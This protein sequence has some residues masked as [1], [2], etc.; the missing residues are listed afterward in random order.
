MTNNK[1]INID[2]DF[3]SNIERLFADLDRKQKDFATRDENFS[4]RG[5]SNRDR[6][7]YERHAYT[8]FQ[9]E[10]DVKGARERIKDFDPTDKRQKDYKKKL[11]DSNLVE[12]DDVFKQTIEELSGTIKQSDVFQKIRHSEWSTLTKKEIDALIAETQQR[13]AKAAINGDGTQEL[14]KDLKYLKSLG[15]TKPKE[16]DSTAFERFNKR[17]NITSAL[18]RTA[19]SI[20]GGIGN[21]TGA[22]TRDI[23]NGIS[24]YQNA[25]G[26]GAGLF[27]GLAAGA[28]GSLVG[29]MGLLLQKGNELQHT[30]LD[31]QKSSNVGRGNFGGSIEGNLENIGIDRVE[32]NQRAGNVMRNRGF[33]GKGLEA[34]TLRQLQLEK[35]LGLTEGDINGVS[36]TSKYDKSGLSTQEVIAGITNNLDSKGIL[37]LDPQKFDVTILPKYL[38]KI[39]N[40]NQKQLDETGKVN[41]KQAVDLLSRFTNIGGADSVF[42]NQDIALKAIEGLTETFKNPKDDLQ[43]FRNTQAVIRAARSNGEDISN[44]PFEV[45]KRSENIQNNPDAL[46]ER[47]LEIFGDVTKD[48]LKDDAQLKAQ[49]LSRVKGVTGL[50]ATLSEEFAKEFLSDSDALKQKGVIGKFGKGFDAAGRARSNT[51]K[52]EGTEADVTNK[53]ARIGD[54]IGQGVADGIT[55]LVEFG[56][57]GAEY[58]KKISNTLDKIADFF[59]SGHTVVKANAIPL[60]KYG[61]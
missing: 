50:S 33:G 5:A 23:I 45:L 1:K 24:T 28:G 8:Q 30:Y 27:G 57:K 49:I 39:A 15:N 16:D 19:N 58:T 25:R 9:K 17:Y 46:R 52:F 56:A 7:S 12:Q 32:F 55:Q 34:E 47:M 36:R 54:T 53:V 6:L 21:T 11:A 13:K 2:V 14:D 31:L 37:S 4:L 60:N 42:K 48:Q 10:Y 59:G 51:G 22:V 41:S 35:S 38:E 20:G 61:K 26:A 43:Q 18:D 44:D 3:S 29:M 40:I